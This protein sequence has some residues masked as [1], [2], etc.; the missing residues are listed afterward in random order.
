MKTK[1]QEYRTSDINE[2]VA[3]STIFPLVHKSKDKN[4]NKIVFIFDH[5]PEF[6]EARDRFWKKDLPI[7]AYT[8]LGQDRYLKTLMRHMSQNG[9]AA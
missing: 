7:D 3:L 5:S 2:V 9:R 1:Y 8:L 4:L 6:E